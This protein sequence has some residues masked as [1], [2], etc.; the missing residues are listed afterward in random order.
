MIGM[1]KYLLPLVLLLVPCSALARDV[2]FEVA[3]G[4]GP[5]VGFSAVWG[6]TP[7]LAWSFTTFAELQGGP[8]QTGSATVQTSSY[9]VGVRA[10][11]RFGS[12]DARVRGTVGAGIHAGWFGSTFRPVAEA[13][14]GARLQ[15]TRRLYGFVDS[16]IAVPLMDVAAWDWRLSLGIGFQLRF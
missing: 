1:W 15:L 11:Y 3:V 9:T 6:V 14:A 7:H 5:S 12:A 13:L 8:T 10:M 2:S 4:T 16:S